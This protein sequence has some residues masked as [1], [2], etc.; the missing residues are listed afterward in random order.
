[1]A[2]VLWSGALDVPPA[3]ALKECGVS[4][5]LACFEMCRQKCWTL[6]LANAVQCL[7]HA[8]DFNHLD[9]LLFNAC[10]LS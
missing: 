5:P 8:F 1:M 2:L 4:E 10:M 9:V 6:T 3:A 7:K